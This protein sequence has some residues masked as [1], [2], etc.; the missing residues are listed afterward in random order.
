MTDFEHVPENVETGENPFQ[1]V[2]HYRDLVDEVHE[3]VVVESEHPITGSQNYD[4]QE[5]FRE[6]ASSLGDEIQELQDANVEAALETASFWTGVATGYR[7]EVVDEK[8]PYA[9]GVA[10]N[11]LEQVPEVTEEQYGEEVVSINEAMQVGQD[12]F[13]QGFNTYDEVMEEAGYAENH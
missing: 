6:L 1:T 9:G 5:F 3:E 12:I 13:E 4:D 7:M 10:H 8:E 2:N 11:V